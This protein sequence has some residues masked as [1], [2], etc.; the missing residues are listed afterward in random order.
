VDLARKGA[1]L[2]VRKEGVTTARGRAPARQW[3]AYAALA[4]AVGGMAWSAL[5]VRWAG[6][7]GAASAFYRVSIAAAVLVPWRMIRGSS[8]PLEY[9]SI[10]LA[11]AGG[12]F[13]ALDLVLF[14][15]AVLR[16]TAA[17]AVLL[18]N[19]APIFVGLG[20]WIFF[21]DRPRAAFWVGLALA[22]GGC[23]F[24]VFA[25]ASS[26]QSLAGDVTGDLLALSAAVFWA[27]YMVTTGHVRTAMDTL[28]FNTFA[29]A[30][31]VISL[32]LICLALRV[33]LSGYSGQTWAALF[34]LGFISQ[35]ASYYALVYALGHL[36]ATVTS[37]SVLA[38]VPLTALLAAALLGEPLSSAQIAG[39]LVVLSG[40]YVVSRP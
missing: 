4:A 24:I 1:Q 40:I 8:R 11:L 29:I 3:L 37:V 15:S 20:T 12:A 28:T 7:P 13:F 17:T 26:G 33:P 6:I 9:R 21:K 23:A 35:L 38:Q 27:A 16:T 34:G 10:L 5:F 14:N 36:P 25:D 22:L 18:G 19:N 30:G 2:E 31:S 39:G 32:G